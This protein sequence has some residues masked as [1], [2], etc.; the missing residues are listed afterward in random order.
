MMEIT[1]A[2]LVKNGLI[3]CLFIRTFGY[4]LLYLKLYK[5][6]YNNSAN[7]YHYLTKGVVESLILYQ[8]RGE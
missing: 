8:F 2:L 5:Y 3:N 6:N 4:T 7:S 1:H